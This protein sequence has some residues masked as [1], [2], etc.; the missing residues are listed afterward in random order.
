V[1]F[2]YLVAAVVITTQLLSAP[3]ALDRNPGEVTCPKSRHGRWL[4]LA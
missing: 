4:G 3:G 2:V 1:T